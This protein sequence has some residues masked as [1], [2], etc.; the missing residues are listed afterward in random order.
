MHKDLGVQSQV[1]RPS[2][3]TFQRPDVVRLGV[4][5]AAGRRAQVHYRAAHDGEAVASEDAYAPRNLHP[6]QL[7]FVASDH[8]DREAMSFPGASQLTPSPGGALTS[9]ARLD[10]FA[11]LVAFVEAEGRFGGAASLAALFAS[12]AAISER[13]PPATS[14]V[15]AAASAAAAESRVAA[16]FFAASAAPVGGAGGATSSCARGARSPSAGTAMPWDPP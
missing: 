12:P 4:Y 7:L 10:V 9:A 16:T 3:V 1:P 2:E 6:Q 5:Q 15:E 14:F 11:A 8:H 13:A